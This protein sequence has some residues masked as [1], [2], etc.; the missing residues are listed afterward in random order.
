[1]RPAHAT[2]LPPHGAGVVLARRFV[3]AVLTEQGL[4]GIV[5][6]VVLAA[7]E[8][9]TNAVL[10]ARTA[11]ELS[12]EVTPTTVRVSVHD[13]DR[14]L[15]VVRDH[16]LTATTGR[17]LAMV[18]ALAQ[19]IGAAPTPQ[20]KVVWFTVPHLPT[21]DRSGGSGSG[22]PPG[23]SGGAVRSVR[24]GRSGRSGTATRP[25]PL[26]PPALPASGAG[27]P[28][29]TLDGLPVAWWRAARRHEEAALRELALLHGDS[30][31][32][33]PEGWAWFADSASALAEV[34][35]PVERA[36]LGVAEP[37]TT[38]RVEVVVTPG[39]AE[40]VGRLMET[41]AEAEDRAAAGELLLPAAPPPL[42]AARRWRFG[43]VLA[44]ADGAP[45]VTWRDWLRQELPAL[46]GVRAQTS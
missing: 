19:E 2:T 23:T 18:A 43:Q 34:D 13:E 39:L 8:L 37:P 16:G 14:T 31:P 9:V 12:L 27:R 11:V 25:G 44:Q 46:A 5:D 32:P 24:S 3:R 17:G 4:H 29:V 30:L 42:L 35:A 41:L 22:G 21:Q 6:D 1:M 7:C 40:R 20:G 36:T 33:T 38:V 45:A 15:P 28:R 10:H 26:G